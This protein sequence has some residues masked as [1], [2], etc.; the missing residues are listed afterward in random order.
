MRTSSVSKQVLLLSNRLTYNY[1]LEAVTKDVSFVPPVALRAGTV[2][3]T[4]LFLYREPPVIS[5]YTV[6]AVGGYYMPPPSAIKTHSIGGTALLLSNAKVRSYVLEAIGSDGSF[7]TP[8]Q[9]RSKSISLTALTIVPLSVA[10]KR[11]SVEAVGFGSTP[12]PSRVYTLEAVSGLPYS[13]KSYNF[14]VEAVAQSTIEPPRPQTQ[15]VW[16]TI[17]D[18]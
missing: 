16:F 15:I 3:K 13:A 8:G 11:F 5:S 9:I 17:G 6:E 2:S 1:D 7:V 18:P 10:D 4:A 14:V 12:T